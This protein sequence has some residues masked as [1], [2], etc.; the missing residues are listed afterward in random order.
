M[1]PQVK[2]QFTLQDDQYKFPYHHLVRF[3]IF[4]TQAVL[5]W[6]F[7]YYAYLVNILN[8][9][10]NLAPSSVLDVGCG[11]GKMLYELAHH[12]SIKDLHGID[13]SERA[14]YFAKAFN[15]GNRCIFESRDIGS[16]VS[17]YD[18]VTV[19]EVMEHIPDTEI[20]DV[21][22]NIFKCVKP[23][24]RVVVSVPSVNFPVAKKHY[25]HYDEQ[26]LIRQF[27]C[28]E[29]E[30]MEYVVR[31]NFLYV[32]LVKLF[33]KLSGFIKIRALMFKFAHRFI[34]EASKETGRHIICV[35]KKK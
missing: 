27:S 35:F 5:P 22:N 20:K 31:Q 28:F 15:Y 1:L 29:L 26:L 4:N 3:D 14:I 8:K 17:T 16:V 18:I 7:E 2:N 21:V 33:G 19:V 24:G 25:R 11:D 34:F 32:L 23:G 10:K 13:L 12:S 9:I 6:G 30:S